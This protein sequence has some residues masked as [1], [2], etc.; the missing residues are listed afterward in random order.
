MEIGSSRIFFISLSLLMYGSSLAQTSIRTDVGVQLPAVVRSK[1]GALIK[2]LTADDFEAFEGDNRLKIDLD[3]KLD[4]PATIGIVFDLSGSTIVNIGETVDG[5]QSLVDGAPANS[6]FFLCVVWRN[7]VSEIETTTD[8]KRIRASLDEVRKYKPVGNTLLFD[9]IRRAIDRLGA[10]VFDKR[11]L[12]VISDGQD[13]ISTNT[14]I[15]DLLNLVR[16]GSVVTYT[17]N[18]A[19]RESLLS[20]LGQ[21]GNLFLVQLTESGGGRPFGNSGG[22]AFGVKESMDSTWPKEI[23]DEI[24]NMYFFKATVQSTPKKPKWRKIDLRLTKVA[25]ERL[26]SVKLRVRRGIYI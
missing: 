19:E 24:C 2:N 18:I 12:I 11:I 20:S 1:D 15:D 6:E 26:G 13:N 14:D 16:V 5:I 7:N 8:R 25:K 22:L 17:V 23:V 10:G 4:A 9:S 21:R 3:G